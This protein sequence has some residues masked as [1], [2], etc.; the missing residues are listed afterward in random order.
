MESTNPQAKQTYRK[1]F[2]PLESDP[3]VFT[4]L[5]H[6]LG[7]PKTFGFQDVLSIHDPDLL[8][9]IPRPVY[10]L[11]LVFPGTETYDAR[12]AEEDRER[13]EYD[14][15]GEHEDVVFFKQTINNA[16]GL[17]AI[18]HGV[19][20]GELRSS[21]A[22]ESLLESLLEKCTPLKS[23]ERALVLEDSQE[24]EQVYASVA[25]KGDTEAPTD[26]Q[27]EVD[28]HYICFVKSQ[29]SGHLFQM[30]GDRKRPV[31]L[32]QLADEDDVLSE[33]CLEVIRRWIE[34]E[35][36]ENIGFNLM[37]LVAQ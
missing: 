28:Y 26:P 34:G 20:N 6:K 12:V 18:L 37:A 7:V 2:I 23:D 19:C 14:V 32:A 13:E 33:K 4:E 35:K 17:Y 25:S 5:I 10:A 31:D 1:H 15:A 9:F 22:T 29:K 36:N 11:I 3:E 16:C 24:L 30:D 27:A 8:A 21:I